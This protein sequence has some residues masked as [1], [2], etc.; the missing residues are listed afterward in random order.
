MAT[1]TH[2]S[3]PD[4]PQVQGY[5]QAVRVAGASEL[6]FVSGQVPVRADGTVPDTP[7]EQTR[8]VLANLE[9]QLRA[10][11]FGLSDVVKL[12]ILAASREHAPRVMPILAEAMG[13]T[14]PALTGIFC[15]QYD[16]SWHLEIEAVAA[17]GGSA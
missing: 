14:L 8:V 17:R 4:G 13:G 6:L 12:T 2:V 1:I 11:G 7:E 3:A 15:E 9:A 10:A 5:A 16:P